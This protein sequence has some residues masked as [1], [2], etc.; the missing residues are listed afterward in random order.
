MM[1][2][3]PARWL[4]ALIELYL[5]FTAFV[6]DQIVSCANAKAYIK[7]RENELHSALRALSYFIW[8]IMQ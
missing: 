7:G 1:C 5:T 2:V 3:R 6:L 4:M 8:Y